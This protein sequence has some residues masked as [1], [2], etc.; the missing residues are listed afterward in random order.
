VETVG[1][2]L[3][4]IR[5]DKSANVSK[6]KL[7]IEQHSTNN[8]PCFALGNLIRKKLRIMTGENVLLPPPQLPCQQFWEKKY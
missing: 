2:F 8:L 7:R 1:H 3:N 6:T 4:K 5:K